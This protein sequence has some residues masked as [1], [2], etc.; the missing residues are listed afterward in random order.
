[1]APRN[2]RVAHPAAE[3]ECHR[4][5]RDIAAADHYCARAVYGYLVIV[6][7]REHAARRAWNEVAPLRAVDA[8][9][10]EIVTISFLNPNSSASRRLLRTYCI[11]A[12]FS[13]TRTAA[14]PGTRL[15]SSANSRAWR[16]NSGFRCSLTLRPSMIIAGIGFQIEM[17]ARGRQPFGS[18]MV[19][20]REARNVF[21]GFPGLW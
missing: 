15:W 9:S 11:E 10:S 3:N 6:E 18:V 5:S 12:G 14:S 1:M 17:I 4:F 8:S 21:V 16:R 20:T 2:G 7:Q 19:V 13:P